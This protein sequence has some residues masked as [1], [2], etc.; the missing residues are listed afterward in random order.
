MSSTILDLGCGTGKWP[1]RLDPPPDDTFLIGVDISQRSCV[2]AAQRDSKPRWICVCA[3]GE[4]LPLKD[5]T[6]DS[7]VSN[8]ALPYMD[9]PGT[10][11]ELHRVLKPG[12][13]V[14]LSLHPF[15][16]WLHDLQNHPPWMP[17]ALLYRFYVAANGLL[18]HWSSHLMRYPLSRRRVESWQSERGTGLALKRAGFTGIRF[19]HLQN[20][21][22]IVQALR[23][24]P[25]EEIRPEAAVAA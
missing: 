21:S 8:V 14:N 20:G 13:S 19:T 25:M 6:V 7:V 5:Q 17:P 10:L 23:P 9:I 16:F 1:K 18:F 3:R 11:R 22:F 4:Q 2:Q 12:G 24:A 15:S